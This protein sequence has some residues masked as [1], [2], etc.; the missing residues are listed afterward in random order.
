MNHLG[1]V[2][3]LHGFGGGPHEFIPLARRL[4][5][6]GYLVSCPLLAGHEEIPKKLARTKCTQWIKSAED[7]LIALDADPSQVVVIGFSMGGLLATQLS[8]KYRF[9]AM[10][11]INTPVDFWNIPQVGANLLEDLC[12]RSTRNIRR[13]L[14]AKHRS[15]FRAMVQF[16]MLLCETKKRFRSI[17]CPLL[18]VQTLDDDTVGLKSAEFI[19]RRASSQDKSI[20]YFEKGGHG[21]L[22]SPWSDPVM[23]TVLDWVRRIAQQRR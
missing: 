5:K 7:A 6:E 19:Y 17:Q 14:N 20:S 16:R 13:Y 21:V 10:V 2:L 4:K 23:D 1:H 18:V 22:R 3:L 15:P 8:S 11:T 12:Q 9:K